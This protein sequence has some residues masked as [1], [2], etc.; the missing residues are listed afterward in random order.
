M[1]WSWA[2]HG[3]GDGTGATFTPQSV[4]ALLQ[5][6]G[7]TVPAGALKVKNVAAVMVTATLPAYVRNG[8]T[9][10][11]TVSSLGDATSLQGGTLLQTPLQAANG[12]VY[13]AAQGPVSVGGFLPGERAVRCPKTT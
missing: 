1:A 10:D 6:F 4:A 2:W 13:A 11:V 7:V 12:Q 8:S 3:T 9:V 5:K